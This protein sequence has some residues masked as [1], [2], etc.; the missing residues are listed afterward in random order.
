[1]RRF[2]F[3]LSLALGCLHP[4]YLLAHITS[5][6]LTEWMLFYEAEPWGSDMDFLRS[7][8]VASTIANCHRDSRKPAFK[9]SDF[10]P[11]SQ[12]GKPHGQTMAETK[13][14]MDASMAALKHNSSRKK[15]KL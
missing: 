4:D 15:K 8:I 13:A 10:M 9:P 1:M 11:Q 7:G 14:K 2:A 12:S 5:R 6:Q 3:R